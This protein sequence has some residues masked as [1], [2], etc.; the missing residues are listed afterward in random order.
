V[1]HAQAGSVF[2]FMTAGYG[3]GLLCSGPLCSRTSPRAA[4][5]LS[6]AVIG[7]TLLALASFTTFATLRAA[8]AVLGFAAGLYL[9][10]GIGAITAAVSPP[11]WGTAL[12]LHE[13]APNL[14]FAVTPLVAEALLAHLSWRGVIAV[15]GLAPLAVGLAGPLLPRMGGTVTPRSATPAPLRAPALAFW[16]LV[17]L[18][19]LGTGLNIGVLT[20]LPLYLAAELGLERT[21]A[22]HLVA[23]SRIL[24]CLTLL[25]AGWFADRVGPRRALTVALCVSAATTTALGLVPRAAVPAAVLLQPMV[26]AWIFPALFALLSALGPRSVAL[27]SPLA[28]IVGGGLVPAA[29]G[30]FGERGLFREAFVLLGGI[31]LAGALLAPLLEAAWA[32]AERAREAA[33]PVAPRHPRY[34]K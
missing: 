34:W 25:A 20:M 13:L 23:V 17:G 22:N 24:P 32:P 9:P 21:A 12:A 14:A 15:F 7:A 33:R 3:A 28:M 18:A 6:S 5:A 26:T 11:R 8:M 31:S 29:I 27:A 10:A 4:I 16:T 30:A 2:L 1:G 19:G